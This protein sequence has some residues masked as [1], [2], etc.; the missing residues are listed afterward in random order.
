MKA[1]EKRFLQFLEG[2]EK[3]F[4]IPVY[5]RNYDWKRE[6][7]K[8]LFDDIVQIIHD[9]YRTHFMGT[10]VAFQ[11]DGYGKELLIIDGQQRLTTVSLIL[12]AIYK[13]LENGDVPDA[14]ILKGKIYEEFLINK[15]SE[16]QS[17]KVRL[18][19]VK[20]DREA[21]NS[22]FE[23]EEKEDSNVTINYHYFYERIIAGE[24]S[25]EELY[26]A[27]EQLIIVDIR[28]KKGEDDPQLIFESLNS[29]GLDLEESDKVRNFILMKESSQKQE[30]LYRDYWYKIEKNTSFNVS[31]FLRDYLTMKDRRIPRKDKVYLIFKE[32]IQKKNIDVHELLIELLRYSNYYCSIINSVD[33]DKQISDTLRRI[34]KLETVVA[35]PFFLEVYEMEKQGIISHK[36]LGEILSIIESY[37]FRRFISDVPTNALNKTF[38]LLG[39]DIGSYDDYKENYLEVF[40][41]VL[42]SKTG[43][44]RFPDYAEFGA[45]LLTKDIYN[46]QGRNKLYLLER[47]E[48]YNHRES[49]ITALIDEGTLSIEHIMPQTLTP[50]WRKELGDDHQRIHETYLHTLGNI[51]LTGY[52]SKYSNKSFGEK[53]SMEKGFNESVLFLNKYLSSINEWTEECIQERANILMKKALEIWKYP[54]STYVVKKDVTKSFTLSSEDSFTGKWIVEWSFEE[55][56][57]GVES[58]KDFYEGLIKA[59]YEKD[60]LLMK[61]FLRDYNLSNKF[62]EADDGTKY[63]SKIDTDFYLIVGTNTDSKISAMKLILDR[64]DIDPDEVSF[65]IK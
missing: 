58:W 17:K 50:A 59:L 7:C 8:Q 41:H 53:K 29:T 25:I 55:Q 39:K 27:I 10:I 64:F 45:G 2:S 16:D 28:L 56:N 32:F 49:D 6:Q 5:Q 36:E 42:L 30:E 18:K 62:L 37:V 60:K 33:S 54:E 51:T 15:Y 57:Y 21:F 43:S 4:V 31:S 63:L 52:N 11:E 24:V 47:L 14:G 9:D 23:G 22:I 46:T 48:N 13:A 38:M 34:N 40:K 20:D 1:E 26:R 12:L 65:Y 3:S 19:P 44:Q 61:S 35:Y